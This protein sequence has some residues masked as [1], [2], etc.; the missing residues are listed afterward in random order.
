MERNF[1]FILDHL[2]WKTT[3]LLLISNTYFSN[4]AEYVNPV[5]L[6]LVLLLLMT[7][8]HINGIF[9]MKNILQ[10]ENI[11]FMSLSSTV[12]F[13]QDILCVPFTVIMCVMLENT[14]FTVSQTFGNCYWKVFEKLFLRLYKKSVERIED[15]ESCSEVHVNTLNMRTFNK[16]IAPFFYF[17]LKVHMILPGPW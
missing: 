10:E 17:F 1:S 9:S 2:R 14:V 13:C 12:F 6:E 3:Q 8:I 16:T 11:F 15:E 5:K 4:H 7:V